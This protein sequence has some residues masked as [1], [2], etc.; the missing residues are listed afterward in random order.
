MAR[1]KGS[2]FSCDGN[3]YTNIT[4]KVYKSEADI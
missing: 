3:K 2:K 1:E 4:F